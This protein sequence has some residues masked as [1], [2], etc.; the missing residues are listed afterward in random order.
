MLIWEKRFF[1]NEK[2]AF[3]SSFIVVVDQNFQ[4]RLLLLKK[5]LLYGK[6][7]RFNVIVYAGVSYAL[8]VHFVFNIISVQ[9]MIFRVISKTGC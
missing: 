2:T 3:F 9:P 5:I 1:G 4:R 7:K 6:M 8:V